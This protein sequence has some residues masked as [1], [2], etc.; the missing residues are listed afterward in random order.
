MI[1]VLICK[2]TGYR[3][4]WF[5]FKINL[6][7]FYIDRSNM[8]WLEYIN[9]NWLVIPF[10]KLSWILAQYLSSQLDDEPQSCVVEFV[11]SFF[12]DNEGWS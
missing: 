6:F 5:Q 2:Q 1:D 8:L 12:E 7:S 4:R 9:A 11:L 10:C 3:K